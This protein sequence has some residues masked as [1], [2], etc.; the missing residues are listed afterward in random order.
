MR[1]DRPLGPDTLEG[2]QAISA[3]KTAHSQ[4]AAGIAGCYNE[5]RPDL[6]NVFIILGLFPLFG[7]KLLPRIGSWFG[8][9]SRRRFRQAKWI[10]SWF[11][12]SEAEFIQAGREYRRECVRE[13]AKEYPGRPSPDDQELIARV[14]ASPKAISER[15]RREFSLHVMPANAF[16]RGASRPSRW[17]GGGVYGLVQWVVRCGVD[18][19]VYASA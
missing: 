4:C 18:G 13:L 19:S 12:G 16:P 9:R 10:W 15:P 6:L 1:G 7:A 5:A 14:G 11:A 3:Q 17:G 8:M 2:N